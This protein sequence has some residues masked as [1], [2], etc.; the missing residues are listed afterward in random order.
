MRHIRLRWVDTLKGIGIILVVFAHHSLPATLDTYIYSFHMPLF[1]FVSGFLFDIGKYAGSTASFVRRRFG[2]LIVPYLFF[3]LLTC[4]FYFLLDTVFE[5]E[6]TNIDFFE[7]DTLYMIYSILFSPGTLVSYNP[8]LWFLPCLFVTELLFYKFVKKSW[9]DQK[10]LILLL[11]A[12]G[13]IGYLYP[14]F[15][16]FRLPWNADVALSAVVFYGAGNLFRKFTKSELEP[17]SSIVLESEFKGNLTQIEKIFFPVLLLLSLLYIG[18]I[19]ESPI[20]DK[21]NMN[22]MEYGNFISFYIPAF[23][24]IF[25]F[26]Y[27][28]KKIG[29]SNILEYYGRN[30]L[31]VLIL[32][33]PIKDLLST[34][35][36]LVFRIDLDA[37]YYNTSI[38][39]GLTVLNLILIVPLISLLNNYFPFLLGKKGSSTNLEGFKLDK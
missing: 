37:D 15:V 8:P 18:Y 29:S 14:A 35:A 10:Q 27:L 31:I 39:L 4:L 12:A 21:S 33:F 13:V 28:S 23:L 17:K 34:L 16:S 1:F 24:G 3:A 19:I 5:P 26:I 25:T 38:A 6:I 36:F 9:G 2:S 7:A 22:S 32:Q 20:T 11:I 30:S